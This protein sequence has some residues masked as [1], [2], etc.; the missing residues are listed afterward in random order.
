[1]IILR[2]NLSNVKAITCIDPI[3]TSHRRRRR[4]S[5]SVNTLIFHGNCDEAMVELIVMGQ[6]KYYDWCEIGENVVKHNTFLEV[7]LTPISNLLRRDQIEFSLDSQAGILATTH[8]GKKV[9]SKDGRS[10]QLPSPCEIIFHFTCL[11]LII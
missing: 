7:E 9:L 1:M 10:S 6:M 2:T 11:K 4:A 3:K 8:F 5:L